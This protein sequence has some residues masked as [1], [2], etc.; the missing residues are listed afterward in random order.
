MIDLLLDRFQAWLNKTNEWVLF[1][2]CSNQIMISHLRRS[3]VKR[4]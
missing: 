4:M 3:Q 1:H 2:Y